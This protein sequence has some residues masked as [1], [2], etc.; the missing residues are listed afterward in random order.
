MDPKDDPLINH[1]RYRTLKYIN[2]GSFGF[3]VLAESRD[4]RETVAI[5]FV[6]VTNES[7]RKHSHREIMNHQSLLHPHVVQLKEVMCVPPFLAIVMEFVP[8]GDMF[9][10]VVSRRGLPEAEARWF[11][12]QLIL[13]MDY[14][15]RK[16]IMSRDIKLENTLLV[17]QPDKKPLLKLCDFG[18]SKHELLDSVAKSKV[19][20][21][22]YTAPEVISNLK[23][24]DGKVADVWSA[25][26]ML[27]T[28]LFA[29]YPFER[30]EDKKL[31]QNERLQRILHRI[32]KVDY[33]FPE[34]ATISDDCR[35]LIG[36]ILVADPQQRITIREIQH[37]PWFQHDLP[38]GSLEY[39]DWALNLEV[40]PAQTS[41]GV[42]AIIKASRDAYDSKNRSGR[43]EADIFSS[44]LMAG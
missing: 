19:G 29:R 27:F 20:T 1:P 18:Y 7:D 6:E 21:P 31:R 34:H 17:L 5:K 11:F 37:H 40:T 43:D 15:H 25:G 10:Y 22:G 36:R 41:E 38:P 14:C 8:G 33:L 28:M 39:N 12:Q 13:G 16:G 4:T 26:V 30:P 3:V 42:D 9:Q 23:G 2:K 44:G 24:Y 32:M 35:G